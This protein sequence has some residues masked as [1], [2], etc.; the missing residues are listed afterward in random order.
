MVGGA[1]RGAGCSTVK[2]H[3]FSGFGAPWRAPWREVL[4]GDRWVHLFERY[5]RY[6]P[7]GCDG[8][9]KPPFGVIHRPG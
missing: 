9:H 5:L 1:D 8:R 2:P 3:C 6:H 7:K 4:H